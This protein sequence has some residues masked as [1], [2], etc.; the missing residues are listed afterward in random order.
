[1]VIYHKYD[2][3]HLAIRNHMKW[4][5][6]GKCGSDRLNFVACVYRPPRSP[7]EKSEKS[8]TVYYLYNSK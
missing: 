6:I 8:V 5:F 3:D 4:K 1:M 7:K 2:V